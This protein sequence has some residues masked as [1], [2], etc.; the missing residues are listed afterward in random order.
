MP[1]LSSPNDSMGPPF[2]ARVR[3]S[4]VITAALQANKQATGAAA[5]M[6]ETGTRTV[7]FGL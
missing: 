2:A 4:L 5:A 3:A 7:T 6:P 1:E